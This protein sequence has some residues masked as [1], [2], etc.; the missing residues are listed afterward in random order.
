MNKRT[1]KKELVKKTRSLP[2]SEHTC[3]LLVENTLDGVYILAPPHGFE[4]VNSA[5]A[6][7]AGYDAAEICKK[8]FPY[9]QLIH[10]DDRGILRKR[11]AMGEAG[12]KLPARF[13]VRVMGKD[14]GFKYV[15]NSAAVL[16]GKKLRIIGTV[17][18]ITEQKK[19]EKDSQELTDKLRR[20]LGNTI[21][22]IVLT[23]EIKAPFTSGHQ[24]R[25][26]DLARAI[27]TE[28]GLSKDMIDGIR[29]AG[30][31]HDLGMIGVPAEILSKSSRLTELEYGLIK[32]HPQLAFGILK[33]IEFVWPIASIILQHHERLN[34]SG[35]PGGLSGESILLEARILAVADVVE[36]M[37]S[38]RPYRPSLGI[39]EALLEIS[40]NRGILYDAHA[41]DACLQLFK[42][43]H[44]AFT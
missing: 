10:P 36:A 43:K 44:Y 4:Y 25:V 3:R 14:G 41:A 19:A 2:E 16:P 39:K 24:R 8:D 7:L 28:M 20:S 34:G 33:D 42:E 11:K 29:S 30:A 21:K 38:H 5:F 6:R 23:V 12:K 18:D 40:R 26:A 17:R 13:I 32:T 37:S 35:Y 22:A 1:A 27:A 15:E 9:I 31:I